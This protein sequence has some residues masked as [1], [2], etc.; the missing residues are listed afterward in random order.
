M[1]V[2]SEN[3]FVKINHRFLSSVLFRKSLFHVN[4]VT[5]C[6][7]GMEVL[8]KQEFSQCLCN[9]NTFV[10]K[11]ACSKQGNKT[12]FCYFLYKVRNMNAQAC[13]VYCAFSKSQ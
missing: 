3:K 2:D 9:F 7:F 12:V 13:A 5:L 8:R 4:F 10:R 11:L 6:N 1:E